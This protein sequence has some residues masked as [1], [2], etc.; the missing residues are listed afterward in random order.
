MPD[1]VA[2][3]YAPPG[4]YM[5]D[6]T[7][8]RRDGW[9]HLFNISGTAGFYHG[10]NGNEET[11]AW[12]V[13]RDL[14]DW[15]LRGHVLH[16]SGRAGTFDQHEI[17][18]PFCLDTGKGLYLFYTGVVHP[19]RPLEY[20]KL[21][22]RHPWVSRGH[23]ETQGV[24]VSPDLTEWV[25][26]SD[27]AMGSGVPGRDS[28]VVR[29]ES[30]DRWLLYSTVGTH[31]VNV[32]ASK[33]LTSWQSLGVC[34]RLPPLSLDD[35]RVGGTTRA[36]LGIRELHTAES[37]TV[38]RHPIDGGWI[39]LANWHY[40]RSDDPTDFGS[41]P[42]CLYDNTC[43]GRAVDMGYACE[44]VEHDGSWYRSGTFGPC[45]YWRLGFTRIEWVPGGAF[46]VLEP[47]ALDGS[48]GGAATA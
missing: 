26:V 45:D 28:H 23:L 39:L 22:H 36:L 38:M 5:K 21:G 35:P 47:S 6:H 25:K 48:A 17:W 32:S 34:A 29:D 16:A 46:R 7:L 10:Y 24:A 1:P 14:V 40:I 27:P 41:G 11:I 13:S 43:N 2:C 9:W 12:S 8:V 20:R 37:T 31:E 4:E 44:V 3:A 33:D 42:A 30:G 19:H 15:Q 18:A